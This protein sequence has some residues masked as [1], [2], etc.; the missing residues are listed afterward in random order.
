MP[1]T[2]GLTH[3]ALAVRDPARSAAF[4]SAVFGCV[5]TWNSEGWIE[6]STPGCHDVISFRSDLPDPGKSAGIVHFGFRLRAPEA[7]DNAVAAV[8][9]A[10]GRIKEQGEFSPGHPYAFFEDPDGYEVEVWYE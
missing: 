5:E 3:I 1:D 2:F 8:K 6:V 7:I 9:R 10:G 4:Y